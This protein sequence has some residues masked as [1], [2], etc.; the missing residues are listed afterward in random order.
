MS[1]N[2]DL[3]FYGRNRVA[4]VTGGGRGIGLEGGSLILD[5]LDMMVNLRDPNAAQTSLLCRT[6]ANLTVRN[7]TVV[8][9][10]PANQP[11]TLVQAEGTT[12][13]GSRIRFEKTLHRGASPRASTS[14][15]DRL[16]WRSGRRS[17]RAARDRSSA[18]ST[19]N[20]EAASDSRSSAEFW[21]AAASVFRCGR[22]QAAMRGDSPLRWSYGRSIPFSAGSRGPGSPASSSRKVLLPAC[23]RDRVDW[24]GRQNLLCGWKRYYASGPEQTLRVSGLAAFRSTWNGTD[25]DSREILASW[26]RPRHPGQAVPAD[27]RPLFPDANQ[28]SFRRRL[29]HSSGLYHPGEYPDHGG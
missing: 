24:Q 6:G 26:P 5:S 21:P 23:L 19:R 27:F 22:R 20:E 16:T 13:R 29:G 17:S 8:L 7:C 14:A 10:N 11:F 15:R 2:N 18:D 12:T 25:Q 3:M 28:C 1:A 4:V 9:V